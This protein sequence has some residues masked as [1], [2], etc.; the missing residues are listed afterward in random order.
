MEY[1]T[2]NLACNQGAQSRLLDEIRGAHCASEATPDYD[3]IAHS[4]WL[5]ACIRESMRLTP[6]VNAHVR[7]LTTDFTY[8]SAKY[9]EPIFIP[10]GAFVL[11]NFGGM[12]QHRDFLQGP[13]NPTEFDPRR[14]MRTEKDAGSGAHNDGE[15]S[16]CAASAE[17]LAAMGACPYAT[18]PHAAGIPFGMGTRKCPGAGFAQ[19]ALMAAAWAVVKTHRVETAP[20]I[21]PLVMRSYGLIRPEV[22]VAPHF[23]FFP[24]N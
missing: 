7:R 4:P 11:V 13:T 20:S 6:T 8:E 5:R 2:Y 10:E 23:R 12:T 24:R 15:G 9:T 14:F 16:A 3:A 21:P 19:C 1:L 18:H 17:K 22:P